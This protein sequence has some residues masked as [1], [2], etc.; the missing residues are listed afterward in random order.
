ML[1]GARRKIEKNWMLF[2]DGP[3]FAVYSVNPHRVLAFSLQGEGDIECR[4]VCALPWPDQYAVQ[5]GELRGGAPPW[6]MGDHFVSFCHSVYGQ[7]GEYRYAAAVYRFSATFPFTPQTVPHRPLDLIRSSR[8][9]RRFPK[10]NPAVGDVI[11]PSGASF[12]GGRWVISFGIDDEYCAI[13]AIPQ[14]QVV[15]ACGPA[16]P[17]L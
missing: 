4:E 11:Y 8:P 17:L 6:R 9:V 3:C 12:D 16:E 14:D 5:F 13:A 7:P 15:L 2:G 10:L 1:V